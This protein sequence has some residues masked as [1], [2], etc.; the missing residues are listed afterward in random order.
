LV[1]P[2]TPSPKLAAQPKQA[3]GVDTTAVGTIPKYKKST[4]K[5]RKASIPPAH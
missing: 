2:P 5:A 4:H 3:A 1:A